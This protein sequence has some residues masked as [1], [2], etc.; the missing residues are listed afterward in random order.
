MFST[1]R[2]YPSKGNGSSETAVFDGSLRNTYLKEFVNEVN[3]KFDVTFRVL[4]VEAEA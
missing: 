4:L 3:S 2:G 1:N